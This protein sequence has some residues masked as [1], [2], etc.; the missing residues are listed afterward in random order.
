MQVVVNLD[1]RVDDM[2]TPV[3]GTRHDAAAFFISGI[4]QGHL[5]RGSL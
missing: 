3:N 5:G 1:D 4:A 2:G